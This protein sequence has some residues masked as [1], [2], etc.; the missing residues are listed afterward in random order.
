MP[1]RRYDPT[2]KEARGI[3]ANAWG[4]EK[5]GKTHF[6][7][8]F[9]DPL[10]LFNLDFGF[11]P[12]AKQ[13]PGD[14]EIYVSDFYIN[15]P[16]DA[17]EAEKI[18]AAFEKDVDEALTALRKAATEGRYGTVVLDTAAGL[19]QLCQLHFVNGVVE[20]RIKINAQKKL[21][22]DPDLIRVFPYDYGKANA[23]MAGN[24]RRIVQA[25][26]QYGING[27][28]LHRCK[29][30]YNDKGEATGAYEF[31]GFG[32]SLA[33]APITLMLGKTQAKGEPPE[34][35]AR[36]QSCRYD[37]SQEGLEFADPSYD[38]LKMLAGME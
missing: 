4:R 26:E 22:T 6:A 32:E 9:P 18:L 19:W 30:V 34:F 17:D 33:I 3:T 31:N 24:M 7:L 29:Q 2:V 5:V 15:R 37:F 13:L 1:F 12:V 36:V 38:T 16:G 28:F 8:T 25:A 27:V 21:P 14:R 35:F 10:Y 11:E 23:W 20:K